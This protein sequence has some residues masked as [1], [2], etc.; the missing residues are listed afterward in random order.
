MIDLSM[1]MPSENSEND[2]DCV[3]EDL[4]GLVENDRSKELLAHEN[5][6]EK[7]GSFSPEVG[8]NSESH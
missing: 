4:S 3:K 2:S 8:V 1:T 7:R 5:A 6:S